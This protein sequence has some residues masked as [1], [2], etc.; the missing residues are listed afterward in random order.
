MLSQQ[1]RV[2]IKEMKDGETDAV[3][4][5]FWICVLHYSKETWFLE[6]TFPNTLQEAF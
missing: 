1:G 5:M 6:K 3:M 4:W 2:H